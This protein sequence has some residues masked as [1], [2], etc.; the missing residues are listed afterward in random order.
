M[1]EKCEMCGC[2]PGEINIVASG[3]GYSVL[4]K[5]EELDKEDSR[6]GNLIEEYQDLAMS[7]L[8]ES[9]RYEPLSDKWKEHDSKADEY[10][11][12]LNSLIDDQFKIREQI[13]ELER[14]V[15]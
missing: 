6:L 5:L 14:K 9:E 7:E 8:V 3:E 4:A 10:H 13:E 12:I 1:C 15:K 2:K 11:D